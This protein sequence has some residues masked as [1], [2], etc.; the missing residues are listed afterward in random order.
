MIKVYKFKYIN[1]YM[2]SEE[3]H[4]WRGRLGRGYWIMRRVFE[5]VT[6]ILKNM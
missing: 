5:I 1:C 3:I 6:D 2:N 4:S